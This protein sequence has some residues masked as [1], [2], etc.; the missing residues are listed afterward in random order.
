MSQRQTEVR[1][2]KDAGLCKPPGLIEDAEHLFQ[3]SLRCTLLL[4][5]WNP[6][7]RPWRVHRSLARLAT[8]SAVATDN[9]NNAS[10]TVNPR[11]EETPTLRCRVFVANI[12]HLHTASL[13]R[14]LQKSAGTHVITDAGRR[15]TTA[16]R[17]VV[18]R[19]ANG[20]IGAPGVRP[21]TDGVSRVGPTFGGDSF[22]PALRKPR[23]CVDPP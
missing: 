1:Q 19:P 11:P 13:G 18:T 9:A 12:K 10:R 8:Y 23:W 3:L 17:S 22:G 2:A 7:L 14:N 4:R 16:L 20:A 21:R 15:V 6:V 5:R